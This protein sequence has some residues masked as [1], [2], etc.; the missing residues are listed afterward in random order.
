MS[1]VWG[2]GVPSPFGEGVSPPQEGVSPPQSTGGL[3]KHRKLPQRGGLKRVLEY[4][5]FKNTPD[6]HKS[7]VFDISAAYI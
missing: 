4:L 3:G 1:L 2:G 5:E 7:V 6:S